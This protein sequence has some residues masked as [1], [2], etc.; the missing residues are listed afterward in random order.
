MIPIQTP[1]GTFNVWTKRVGNNPKIKLL[2]LHGGPGG[3][4]ECFLPADS[5]LPAAGIEY[6]YYDQLGSYLSD[7]PTDTSLWNINRFVEEVEQLRQALGL[8]PDNFFLL[9]HSWGGIL[10]TE[11]ALAYPNQLKGLIISNMMSSCP[12]Y[13]RYAQEVLGPGLGDSV[14][15]QIK[16]FEAAQDFA[17]PAYLD[18]IFKAHYTRHVLRLPLEKWPP[19]VNR[20]FSHVNPAIYVPMQGPSE[21]GISG[22][23]AN[24]DRTADLPNIKVPTLVIGAKH[25]TMD[26]AFME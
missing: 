21:F 10:A 3:S 23:L 6:Y 15:Q 18:L 25:D 2:L 17:N 8:G 13:G 20:F 4:H 14:F 9:G 16:A 24:W 12:A 7:Q 5:Y 11:Y 22:K 26:P 19:L 1:V